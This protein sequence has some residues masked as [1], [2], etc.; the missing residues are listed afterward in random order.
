MARVNP[1]AKRNKSISRNL[2]LETSDIEFSRFNGINN[3]S[4]PHD[5]GKK[6]LV[7]A[8]NMDI[9]NKGKAKRR[10]G[11][12]KKLTPSGKVHSLWAND[13]ICLYI[14]GTVLKRLFKDYTVSTIR[15]NVSSLP[16]DYVDVN[17]VVYYTSASVNGY[18]KNG[19]DNAYVDSGLNYMEVPKKG[20]HIEYYNGRIYIA[21]N[22]DL[23]YTVGYTFESALRIDMRN[24]VMPFKDEVTMIKAVDDGIYVSIGDIDDRSSIIFLG[25][26]GPEDFKYKVV[27][28]YGAI[29]GTAVKPRS[30]FVGDGIDGTTVMWASRKGICLGENGGRFTNLTAGRYEVTDNRY[31]AGYFRL[32]NGLPQYVATL[33]T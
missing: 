28:D 30:A 15:S 26:S 7:E 24:G 16:M 12:T 1:T 21:Q 3:V 10:T 17:E 14:D 29:E 2:D 5:L 22:H 27:A 18:I 31:G 6:D 8:P 32:R 20:Q 9:D 13:R 19:V 11:Y 4:D 23:W 33:W 25:G